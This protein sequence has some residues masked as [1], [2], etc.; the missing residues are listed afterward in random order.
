MHKDTTLAQTGS[1]R[2]PG[3]GAVSAPVYYS[4]TYSHPALGES[5]GYDYSRTKNP[6]RQM[7][8]DTVA[9]LEEGAGGFAFSSGLAAIDTV[10]RL[11]RPGDRVLVTEDLYGGT[12]R[13]FQQVY[14]VYGIQAVYVDTSDTDA[15]ISRLDDEDIKM[16]FIEN[17]TNPL[18]KVADISAISAA[19]SRRGILTVA[20]TTFLSPYLQN[21][22][23]LGADIVVHSAT[24]YL[25]GHNDVV[26][27]VVAAADEELCEKLGFYQ[28]AA[29]AILGP[30]DSWLVARGLKTLHLRMDRQQSS[31]LTLA[32]FLSSHPEVEKVYYPGLPEHPGH[33]RLK[34]QARGF[35]AMLSFEVKNPALVPVILESV[36]VFMFAESLGGVESLIT[37]PAVQTHADIEPHIRE[38]LG[39]TDRLLRVS[40]GTEHPDDLQA[41]LKQA[42]E[43]GV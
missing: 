30:Q 37:F 16:V 40:V 19:A 34:E 13:L 5:T 33:R 35:G 20:D 28:N 22:L 3:T 25:G 17:P 8:E 42:L 43:K 7:L 23:K 4:A 41:D 10:L 26:A 29:G 1:R 31:A 14:S 15:V 32:E 27:G 6:T 18:L 12:Y 36:N 38:R 21:P 39:V 24:K 9:E 11:L 2:D